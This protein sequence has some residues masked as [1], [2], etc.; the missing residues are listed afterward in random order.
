MSLSS[1]VISVE[2]WS[3]RINAPG[4]LTF[5]IPANHPKA[6]PENLRLFRRV[7]LSRG[8]TAEW[9][10]YIEDK[11]EVD[12]RIEVICTGMLGILARRFAAENKVLNGQ[13]S[14]DAFTLLSE[15]NADQ[16][17][18]IV[19]GTGGV[20]ATSNI[21]LQRRTDLLKAIE[22]KSASVG[23]EFEVDASFALNVVPLLGTDKTSQTSL[24]F[25]RGGQPGTNVNS[26][27]I[28]ES[29]RDMATRVIG[30]S[31]D[32]ADYVWNAPD[33]T[34]YGL[35]EEVRAFNEA[36]NDATLQQ[37]T[38]TYGQQRS[39]PIPDFQIIP[40]PK[41]KTFNQ[42]S[43]E[44][45]ETGFDV[46]DFRVGDLRTVTIQTEN[47]SQTTA[48]RIAEI[49]VTVDDTGSETLALTLSEAGVFV[50]ASYL[51]AAQVKDLSRRIRDMENALS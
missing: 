4:K 38:T 33:Q 10:G 45:E 36:Q 14:A 6:T 50:T 42:I 13:G 8:E 16:D 22:L 7:L 29:G 1:P 9:S 3:H 32:L 39:N 46:T 41:G 34:T 5:S 12:G 25:Q 43:G 47:Q 21:S 11:N 37:L 49:N 51:D 40:Q 18:G 35:I 48:K 20:A 24:I 28:G 31:S 2:R 17:T 44:R 30:T 15:A 19:Q 27:Q 26:M 23:A